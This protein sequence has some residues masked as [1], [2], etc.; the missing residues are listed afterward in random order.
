MKISLNKS[1]AAALLMGTISFQAMAADNVAT[2]NGKPIKQSLYDYIVKEANA[3]GQNIDENT[4]KVIVDKLIASELVFQEAQRQGIDKHPD[5]L[6]K[7]ELTNRELLVNTYLQDYLKKNPVSEADIKAAYDK[8]K[9]EVGNKEYSARHILVAT[10]AEAKDII[11]Q[12]GKGADFAKLAKE[13]SLDPGSK[14]KGGDLGW[15]SLG[16]MVKQFSEAVTK[17]PKGSYTQTP[18]QTQFGWH[19]IKLENS[20]DLQPPAYEKVKEGLQKQLQQRQLEKLL[21]DLRSKA[22]IV[23]GSAPK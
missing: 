14:E 7:Q 8:Y 3:R 16:S 6:A 18:I 17:L 15:F 12:L 13:K 5:Y 22:K 10:E 2:V 23:D 9:T 11:T 1:L 20:R 19:V 4:R 21:S